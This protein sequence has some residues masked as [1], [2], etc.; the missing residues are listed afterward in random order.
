MFHKFVH[1]YMATINDILYTYA[2]IEILF[3]NYPKLFSYF[4]SYSSLSHVVYSNRLLLLFRKVW[5]VHARSLGLSLP[6]FHQH[7]LAGM[8]NVSLIWN[9]A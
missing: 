4:H 9:A 3:E 2:Y 5:A 6:I 7:N 8:V 1:F